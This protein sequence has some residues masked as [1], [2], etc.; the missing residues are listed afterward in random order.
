[1]PVQRSLRAVER[2]RRNLRAHRGFPPG[3]KPNCDRGMTE[4]GNL[5]DRQYFCRTGDATPM[6]TDAA[7]ERRVPQA[8]HNLRN[9][10][11]SRTEDE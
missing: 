9:D 6:I 2:S 4:A 11:A 3:R 5:L 1:L 10:T 8:A 7:F